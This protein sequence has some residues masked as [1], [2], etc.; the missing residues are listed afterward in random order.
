[1]INVAL[2]LEPCRGNR[3]G[4][5]NYTYELARRLTGQEDLQ[6]T[7]NVYGQ[8]GK[9][10]PMPELPV[11]IREFR[12]FPYGVYRRLWH[13]APIP[14]RW[15]FPQRAAL[16][17]FFD[18]IVPPRID[19]AVLTTV[20]DLTYLR[21]PETMKRQ[22]L[23]RISRDIAYSL[24]RSSRIITISRFSRQ[25]LVELLG[26]PEENIEIVPPAPCNPAGAAPMDTVRTRYR[27]RRPFLLYVGTI[28]PRKN[29]TTLLKAFQRL[30]RES[31]LAHQ[32]VLAGG[33][34]WGGGEI[35]RLAEAAGLLEDV[36]VTGY[37]S[38]AERNA[39]YQNAEA[40]AFPSLYEGF[41]IPPLEAMAHGCPVV[42]SSAASLPEVVGDAARLVDP[43]DES[44]MAE[45][46]WQVLTDQAYRSRLI[47]EGYKQSNVY[48]WSAS[49]EKFTD[50]CRAVLAER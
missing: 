49:A 9:A 1:M 20:H 30:R 44:G 17:A 21:C 45:G 14:Y 8:W 16:T 27:I 36:V 31:G 47:E 34:G 32:L 48:S 5:G 39:L 25:E 22:N 35:C 26:V 24:E 40:F 12:G 6:F 2:E 28:E 11:P 23:R 46:L 10:P 13:V 37:L 4:I 7:G 18:Y 33:L 42:C 19:G 43:V 15:M 3:S 38:T 29:L 50:I 41:G